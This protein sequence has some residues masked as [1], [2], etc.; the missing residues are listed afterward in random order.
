MQVAFATP[1][2]VIVCFALVVKLVFVG[3]VINVMPVIK[4]WCKSLT[5][6]IHC[7][8]QFLIAITIAIAAIILLAISRFAV[9]ACTG[10]ACI[11]PQV[12]L[13]LVSFTSLMIIMTVGF[14]AFVV[15]PVYG[16]L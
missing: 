1:V 3:G 7:H 14:C 6:Q 16:D 8:C 13:E 4:N 9:S 10:V 11:A 5:S 2:F 15:S 12:D